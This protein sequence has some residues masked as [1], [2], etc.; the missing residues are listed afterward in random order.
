MPV[1]TRHYYSL[2]LEYKYNRWE[3]NGKHYGNL[4]TDFKD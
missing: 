4:N 3:A 2:S 1:W